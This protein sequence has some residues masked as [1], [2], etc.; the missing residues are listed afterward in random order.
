MEMCSVCWEGYGEVK[1]VYQRQSCNSVASTFC[2]SGWRVILKYRNQWQLFPECIE[3]NH[4]ISVLSQYISLLF[5]PLFASPLLCTFDP[6]LL[7][8]HRVLES[9]E[10]S[11]ILLACS[12]RWGCRHCPRESTG[13]WQQTLLVDHYLPS[14]RVSV[15]SRILDRVIFDDGPPEPKTS[16]SPFLVKGGRGRCRDKISGRFPIPVP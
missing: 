2:N 9:G 5:I 13:D 6:S 8:L 7:I 4:A 15:W 14:E 3:H 11:D 1:R 10:S 16:L 12:N